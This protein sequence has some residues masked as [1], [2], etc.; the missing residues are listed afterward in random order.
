MLASAWR[1]LH[2]AQQARDLAV[3]GLYA[4][5]RH[6]Q[7][8]AFIV[9]MFGFLLQWPTLPT[10]VM[11]PILVFVYTRLARREEQAALEDFGEPYREYMRR[12]PAFIP[13]SKKP[14]TAPHE[15]V[16]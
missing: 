5:I 8:A 6:P 1:V 13:S 9:I 2:K 4:R 7:Y 14:S 11:F 10:L 3:E 16:R 15:H 12:T